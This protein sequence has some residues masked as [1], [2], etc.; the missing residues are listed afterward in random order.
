MDDATRPFRQNAEATVPKIARRLEL[1]RRALG[2][3]AAQLCR[4]SGI[5]PN[6]WSQ[7]ENGVGRPDLDGALQL[8]RTFGLTLD[9]IYEGDISGIRH[10]LAVKIEELAKE[11]PPLKSARGRRPA[12]KLRS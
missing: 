2:M 12:A 1:S 5:A 3:T 6:T 7:W 10:E 9:W 8:T 11:P 4:Q